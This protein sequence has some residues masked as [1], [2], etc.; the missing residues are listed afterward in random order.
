M[1][2]KILPISCEDMVKLAEIVENSLNRIES[3]KYK[4]IDIKY[5]SMFEEWNTCHGT[6][7]SALIIYAIP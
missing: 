6:V 5:S 4:L 2:H 3:N 7:H 1:Q